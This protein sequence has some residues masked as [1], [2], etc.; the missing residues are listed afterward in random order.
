MLEPFPPEW[1]KHLAEVLTYIGTAVLAGLAGWLTKHRQV[2]GRE[3]GGE[4][5]CSGGPE[6]REL[7]DALLKAHPSLAINTVEQIALI[8]RYVSYT[9]PDGA[10]V[11]LLRAV[12][13][14]LAENS[15]N[16]TAIL[17]RM[18]EI[19]ERR[20]TDLEETWTGQERRRTAKPPGR[21]AKED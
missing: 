9:D 5:S 20:L 18:E 6:I 17:G 1:A 19:L 12:L 2:Q 15:R 8:T 13:Q 16:Q 11:S 3:G 10:R 14:A 21:P 4:G 7:R